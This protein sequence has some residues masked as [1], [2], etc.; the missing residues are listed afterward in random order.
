MTSVI[1]TNLTK[2]YN[3]TK[4]AVDDITL[5]I[6]EGEVFGILGPNGAGKT[7]TIKMITGISKPTS[8]KLTVFGYSTS[9]SKV[10]ELIGFV[11]QEL[12]F[13][14]HLKVKENLKLFCKLYDVPDKNERIAYAADLMGLHDFMDQSSGTLS[15]GQKRRLNVAL[16]L[17]HKPKLLVLDEPSAGMD[18]QSRTLLWEGVKKMSDDKITIILTSHLMETADA[19]SDRICIIDHGKILAVATPEELKQSIGKGDVI[20][21]K[22]AEDLSDED[23]KLAHDDLSS[24]SQSMEILSYNHT[25]AITT[26]D[27]VN[28]LSEILPSIEKTVGR[29]NVTNI[30]L[31]DNTLEDVF[32]HMT[33]NKLRE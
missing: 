20:E 5:E 13:Y 22:F 28:A 19:L 21:L 23:L 16:A 12:V 24:L 25:L 17:L 8:G 3:K 7:T 15:G 14:D 4:I 29:E 26:L 9:D 32:I 10:K 1:A 30:S 6:K 2:V 27:G 31:R 33:G 11:P 18:P